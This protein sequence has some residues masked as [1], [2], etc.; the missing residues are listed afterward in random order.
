MAMSFEEAIGVLGGM[1]GD[2]P[3]VTLSMVLES[4]SGNMVGAQSSFQIQNRSFL[5]QNPSF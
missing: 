3:R 2:L 5:M 4:H 1:F